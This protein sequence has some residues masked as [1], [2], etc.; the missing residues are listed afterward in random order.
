MSQLLEQFIGHKEQDNLLAQR[1]GDLER[2]IN[3]EIE[4]CEKKLALQLDKV[5]EGENAEHFKIWG[6]LLTANLYQIKQGK[7]A[8]VI[9]YYDPEQ[10]VLTIPLQENLTPNEN[11]QKYFKKYA[12]AKAGAQ[13]SL[14]Q[15]EHTQDELNYLTASKTA[16][17]PRRRRKICRIS[18]WSWK[19]H[20]T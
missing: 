20:P 7:S 12:K 13:Q 6:E 3:R 14:I 17:R 11:A 4:R 8:Q 2:I 19:A 1:S 10:Q 15:A 9:N 16:C 18:V 5:Q